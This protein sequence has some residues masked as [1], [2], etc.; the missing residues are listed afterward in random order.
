[1]LDG[2][3][4]GGA[5]GRLHLVEAE[6]AGGGAGQT[7]HGRPPGRRYVVK[8]ATL[9]VPLRTL[10]RR[11]RTAV[12]RYATMSVLRA[13]DAGWSSGDDQSSSGSVHRL[14]RDIRQEMQAVVKDH[15]SPV[16]TND[17]DEEA[18]AQP[19]CAAD[20]PFVPPHAWVL[21]P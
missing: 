3:R 14:L 21:A 15:G 13:P 19:L 17:D 8:P 4:C 1:M 5:G 10:L 2:R 7:R 18:Q 9:L 11:L 16:A 6:R 20:V 12:L